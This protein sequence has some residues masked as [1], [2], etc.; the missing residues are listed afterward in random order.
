MLPSRTEPCKVDCHAAPWLLPV[1]S[2]PRSQAY[3]PVF[4]A[5]T[6]GQCYVLHRGMPDLFQQLHQVF[7]Q[8]CSPPGHKVACFDVTGNRIRHAADM[9]GTVLVVPASSVPPCSPVPFSLQA[10]TD[11]RT[12]LQTDGLLVQ[13]SASAAVDVYLALPTH[14]LG[15]LGWSTFFSA[16]PSCN[17][18]LLEAQL[19]QC[20]SSSGLHV[21][22]LRQWLRFLYF[23]G[24]LRSMASEA[25]H[26]AQT[27]QVV[28]VEV[29]VI[30][31]LCWKGAL[32][33]QCTV[34]EM[35]AV[36]DLA[37]YAA[38]CH[39]AARVFSGPFPLPSHMTLR[40]CATSAEVKV[41]RTRYTSTF[42][43]TIMPSCSGGGA[44]DDKVQVA[45]TRV[46]QVCLEQGYSLPEINKIGAQLV[47]QVPM[48]K[49]RLPWT[50]G[51][52]RSSGF[53]C[54]P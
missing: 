11:C 8:A 19:R 49:I 42:V 50:P 22:A 46:A 23:V 30:H 38:S 41:F 26:D 39:P 29:Y 28:Q 51:L 52:S 24:A 21:D 25:L 13:A 33:A 27:A 15:A 16:F 54:M 53:N 3:D 40:Q 7:Q 31:A 14:L 45:K 10:L 32:P 6:S 17:S 35:E 37:S 44:K 2:P 34:A 36:W 48:A 20:S 9:Y 4:L 47:Q 18:E 12:C 1:Q 43:L 5:W